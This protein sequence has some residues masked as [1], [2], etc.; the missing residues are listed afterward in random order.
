MSGGAALLFRRDANISYEKPGM[1]AGLSYIRFCPHARRPFA[2]KA[3][4]AAALVCALIMAPLCLTGRLALALIPAAGAL[5]G[6]LV[7]MFELGA[8]REE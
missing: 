2:K 5:A 4:P 8:K 7:T 3:A 6:H 1:T